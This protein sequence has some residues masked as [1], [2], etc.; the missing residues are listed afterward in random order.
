MQNMV[1]SLQHFGFISD[2]INEPGSSFSSG[3]LLWRAH[4][5]PAGGSTPAA[6]WQLFGAKHAMINWQLM[7][8]G[9]ISGAM[10]C[11]P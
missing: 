2:A 4:N 6:V 1:I 9:L 3:R 10:T 7:W 11:F 8:R 5:P